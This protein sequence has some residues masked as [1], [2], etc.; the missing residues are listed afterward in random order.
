VSALAH[1][2]RRRAEALTG[3]SQ[4]LRIDVRGPAGPARSF[5]V[6]SSED[7]EVRYAGVPL[8]IAVT[9]RPQVLRALWC[10]GIGQQTAAGFGWIAHDEGG[11]RPWR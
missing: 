2:L 9:A 6:S 5:L 3:A 11:G 8:R 7:R 10:W 1:G 4:H